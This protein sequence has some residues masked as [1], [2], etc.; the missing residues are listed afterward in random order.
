MNS[1]GPRLE[2]DAAPWLS[3]RRRYGTGSDS[4][5]QV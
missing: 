2:R 1:R 5:L 4:Q 3:G